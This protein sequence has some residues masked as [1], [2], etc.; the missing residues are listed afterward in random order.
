[1]SMADAQ[2][3]DAHGTDAQGTDAQP[4]RE[5]RGAYC[6]AKPGRTRGSG[7]PARGR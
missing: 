4:R 3:A 6:T 5:G 7:T 2:G 1:M